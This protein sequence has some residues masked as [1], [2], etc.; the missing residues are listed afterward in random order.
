MT[1]L[2]VVWLFPIGLGAWGLGLVLRPKLALACA[3]AAIVGF[4]TGA[5]LILHHP[6][7]LR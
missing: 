4:E 2:G 7:I 5:W 3:L 1:G 6:E